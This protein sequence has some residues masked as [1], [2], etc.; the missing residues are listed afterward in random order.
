MSGQI[1]DAEGG[2]HCGEVRF[3]VQGEVLRNVYCHCANCTASKGASPVH[4]LVVGGEDSVRWLG[5]PEAVTTRSS[6]AL[7]LVSCS[8]CL[9]PLVQYRE[10]KGFRAVFPVL[11]DLRRGVVGDDH[12]ADRLPDE[13]APTAHLNYENR[14]FDWHDALPKFRAFGPG[15]ELESDGRPKSPG[16]A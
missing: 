14:L 15:D 16:A 9:C 3:R 4:L 13:W 12:G 7:R 11:L 8:V 10:G 2:C 5:D 1:L 6:G